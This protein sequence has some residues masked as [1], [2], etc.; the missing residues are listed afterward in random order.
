MKYYYVYIMASK[1]NGVLYIGVTSNLRKRVYQHKSGEYKGF[2][3]KYKTEILVYYETCWDI[4]EAINK[5]KQLKKWKRAWKINL[6][7]KENPDWK[8]LYGEIIN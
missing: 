1:K 5:E 4:K 3:K 6:I 7:E 8:D 2:S